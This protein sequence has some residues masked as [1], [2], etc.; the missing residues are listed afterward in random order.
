MVGSKKNHKKPEL[1]RVIHEPARLQIISYLAT[2]GPEVSFTELG[3]K[4]GLSSGNL[5]VQLKKLEES[6]Y[7]S[8]VKSFK[9]NRPL[10]SVT[11]TKAGMVALKIYLDELEQMIGF[12]KTAMPDHKND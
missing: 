5:S 12:L 10:T 8:I 11:I 4:L 9:D 3:E 1:D 2:G 6:G 7:L